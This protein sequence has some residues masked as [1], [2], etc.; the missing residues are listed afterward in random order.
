[1]P[2]EQTVPIGFNLAYLKT[3]HAISKLLETIFCL[4]AF[5]S[6]VVAAPAYDGIW[7]IWGGA[8]FDS[9]TIIGAVYSF[10]IFLLSLFGI[11]YKVPSKVRNLVETI[12]A[13]LWTIF[14]LAAA[15]VSCQYS[16]VSALIA[17]AI[18]CI[19]AII[20]YASDATVALLKLLINL[21]I[22]ID[23]GFGIVVTGASAQASSKP[24]NQQSFDEPRY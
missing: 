18:F 2:T 14:L 3:F 11:W 22:S 16:Y 1:M 9:F 24:A 5:I 6:S 4:S 20:I 12:F 13:W 15:V 17:A 23:V 8:Y 7:T 19:L 10:A 21:E